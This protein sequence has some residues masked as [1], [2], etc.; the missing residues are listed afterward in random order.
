[1]GRIGGGGGVAEVC[2]C[3]AHVVTREDVRTFTLAD[4]LRVI[5]MLP[6]PSVAQRGLSAGREI[7]IEATQCRAGDTPELE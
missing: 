1:M 7:C 6:W 4:R 2:Y 3:R 5:T